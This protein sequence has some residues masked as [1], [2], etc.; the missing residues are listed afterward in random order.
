MKNFT[1]ETRRHGEEPRSGDRVIRR[2]VS[3]LLDSFRRTLGTL[4]ATA[5]EIFDESAYERF[6]LRNQA[7]RSVKTYGEFLKERE[8]AIATKPRCC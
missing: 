8:S 5:R 7:I 4:R 6:L 1:T 3:A 2:M